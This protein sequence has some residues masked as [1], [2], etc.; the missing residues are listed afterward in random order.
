MNEEWRVSRMRAAYYALVLWA[1]V[2]GCRWVP[3]GGWVAEDAQRSGKR[4]TSGRRWSISSSKFSLSTKDLVELLS[5]RNRFLMVCL[6]NTEWVK[7]FFPQPFYTMCFSIFCWEETKRLVV[8]PGDVAFKSRLYSPKTLEKVLV[9]VGNLQALSKILESQNGWVFFSPKKCVK[10]I[11]HFI[12]IR[13]KLFLTPRNI[14]LNG[15][16]RNTFHLCRPAKLTFIPT[17]YL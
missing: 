12:P 5:Q 6:Y 9:E 11:C 17:T 8:L 10:Y 1:D 3:A 2:I 16:N 4:P 7:Q 15:Q 14:A 13:K